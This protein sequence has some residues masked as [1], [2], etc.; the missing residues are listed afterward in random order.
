MS[1]AELMRNYISL[2]SKV[3]AILYITDLRKVPTDQKILHTAFYNVAGD[4]PEFFEH[5][6][7]KTGGRFPYSESLDQTFP[8]LAISGFIGCQ[9][10]GYEYYFLDDEKRANI[11]KIIMPLFQGR[12]LETIREIGERLKE[13]FSCVSPSL[14]K[15]Y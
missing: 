2:D 7:F 5:L 10:P 6:H 11:E 15:S 3:A 8:G 13:S 4:Y 12:E 9:N 14:G 1:I